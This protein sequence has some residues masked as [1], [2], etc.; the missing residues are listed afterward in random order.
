M[1]G[2][3]SIK[4]FKQLLKT[5]EPI[6]SV[7]HHGRNILHY[8]VVN[9]KIKLLKHIV[10]NYNIDINIQ[11]YYGNTPLYY[12]VIRKR[13][14]C[15]KYLLQQG[16]DINIKNRLDVNPLMLIY[17]HDSAIFF[18]VLIYYIKF[19]SLDTIIKFD[20]CN[21]INFIIHYYPESIVEY[22]MIYSA[23][24]HKSYKVIELLLTSPYVNKN[25]IFNIQGKE[26]TP[27]TCAI[28][29]T[30]DPKMVQILLNHYVD[31]NLIDGIN[32]R[33][34]V[35]A[36]SIQDISRRHKIIEIILSSPFIFINARGKNLES[37]FSKAI[38]YNDE[39]LIKMLIEYGAQIPEDYQSPFINP[40]NDP[41]MVADL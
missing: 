40:E 21:L 7:D 30:C 24:K 27:L 3:N 28:L 6:D 39:G 4:E 14:E 13:V 37:A 35:A 32:N 23:I 8:S 1:Y 41:M 36:V 26:Y 16:A 9:R 15:F 10:T 18:N 17:Y 12:S 11:D 31:V 19:I 33:P 2:A 38:R 29:Y 5:G 22:E 20:A 34:L 25:R